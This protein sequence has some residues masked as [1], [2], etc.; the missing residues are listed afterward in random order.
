MYVL[1]QI[2]PGDWG[3]NFP[4]ETWIDGDYLVQNIDGQHHKFL[5]EYVGN[6]G[7]SHPGTLY[8]VDGGKSVH[9]VDAKRNVR[10]LSLTTLSKR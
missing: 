1:K 3:F 10:S 5:G 8:P 9:Y 6:G 4:Y 2:W 7:T